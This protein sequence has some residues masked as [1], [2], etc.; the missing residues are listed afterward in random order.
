[1]PTAFMHHP[2]Y[3]NL[4]EDWVKFRQT[5]DG[6]DDYIIEYL[7][8]F[9]NRESNADFEKRRDISTVP[10]FAT[11]A[12]NDVNN[13]LFQRFSDISRVG[14]SDSYKK[15]VVG[16][17]HGV[18]LDGST[19]NHFIGRRVLPEL[20]FL[21]KVGIYI[22][23]PVI[24]NQSNVSEIGDLHPYLYI[25]R[26]ED[27]L[28]WSFSFT[29]N[30]F[31]LDKLLLK[32]TFTKSD[33]FGLPIG[34]EIRYRL[35]LL[36]DGNVIVRFFDTSYSQV[37]ALNESSDADIILNI[38][39]IPFVIL[40]L[41]RSLLQD[42]A[43]H[44]IAILNLESSDISYILTA[45]YPFY[46]EQEDGHVRSSHLQ[47]GEDENGAKIAEVGSIQGRT[48]G[49]GLD[50][51]GFINPSSEP[52]TISMEKQTQLKDDI[53]TLVSLAV[54]N[55]KSRFASAESKQ[56]DERGLESGLSA[57]GL[58]LEH[59]E[60]Q[61]AEIYELYENFDE[62]ATIKYPERYSLKST[63]DRLNEAQKL[64]DLKSAAP[65]QLY[66]K[67]IAVMIVQSMLNGRIPS[68]AL[69]DII[70]EIENAKYTV[71]KAE[72]IHTDVER[73]LVS[74]KTA[75][76]A[77]GYAEDEA[78]KAKQDHIERILRIQQAQVKVTNIDLD[79]SP[80]ASARAEKVISQDSD[81]QDDG[82]KAVRG[83]A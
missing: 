34:E 31:V 38:P 16:Q 30:G 58:A 49:K 32:E 55:T 57:I 82:A 33:S 9:S 4:S 72:E 17:N 53:R 51:P 11:N 43:N 77:R 50:R 39:K 59:A 20:L 18:D 83:D 2:E 62:Q 1:M 10:G 41:D 15:V 73:G 81:L 7:K 80:Q 68:D 45:N 25:Y 70:T 44:Q 40:E 22:D 36:Q 8:K 3:L 76:Q 75:S 19:M 56:M 47:D 61:I 60:L 37:N 74:T 52:L 66:Q 29:E 67:A 5:W 14:G 71:G 69:T 26:T 48:Y 46:T 63:L 13:A 78:E 27:I 79:N 65:S 54:A 64:E 24:E 6:G 21:G 35:L 42:V 12:V 23:M 28:N